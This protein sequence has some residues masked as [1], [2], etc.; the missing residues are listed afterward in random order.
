MT[1]KDYK[2]IAYAINSTVSYSEKHGTN[3]KETLTVLIRRLHAVFAGDN[4]RYNGE[5]FSR[6]CWDIDGTD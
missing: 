5:T 4:P 3:A 6:A 2:K 1:E